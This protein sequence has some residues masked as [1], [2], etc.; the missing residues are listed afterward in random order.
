MWV[1]YKW[2]VEWSGPTGVVGDYTW[3]IKEIGLGL[4]R[5]GCFVSIRVRVGHL[6]M[7]MISV[8][9]I[10]EKEIELSYYDGMQMHA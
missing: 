5:W 10:C 6:L 7:F 9:Q 8:Y 2:L 3:G 4:V 1:I